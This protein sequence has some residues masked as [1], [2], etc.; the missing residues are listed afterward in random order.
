MGCLLLCQVPETGYGGLWAL[1]ALAAPAVPGLD[2]VELWSDVARFAD[3]HC[4]GR[5][6]PERELALAALCP[7]HPLCGA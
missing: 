2:L 5:R 6:K 1:Q 7:D 3:A 4:L